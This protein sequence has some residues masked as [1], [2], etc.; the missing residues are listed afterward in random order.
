MEK[1]RNPNINY[2]NS[3]CSNHQLIPQK[4]LKCINRKDAAYEQQEQEM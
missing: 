2:L 3:N 1:V 4:W